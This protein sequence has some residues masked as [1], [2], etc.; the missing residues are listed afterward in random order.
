MCSLNRTNTHIKPDPLTNNRHYRYLCIEKYLLGDSSLKLG[1]SNLDQIT[2][3]GIAK[4]LEILLQK[5]AKVCQNLRGIILFCDSHSNVRI[6]K[7]LENTAIGLQKTIIAQ[8]GFQWLRLYGSSAILFRF[9]SNFDSSSTT[10]RAIELNQVD[11]RLLESDNFV[12]A[13]SFCENLRC[14]KITYC[15]N[16]D[17]QHWTE[18]ARFFK[19]LEYFS[20]SMTK[21]EIPVKFLEQIF[22]SAGDNLKYLKIDHNSNIASTILDELLPYWYLYNLQALEMQGL[23]LKN[24]IVSLKTCKKLKHLTIYQDTINVNSSE[25]LNTLI[26]ELPTTLESLIVRNLSG[27]NIAYSLVKEKES[28]RENLNSYDVKTNVCVNY[29]YE[30]IDPIYFK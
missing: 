26:K 3:I 14:L 1:V 21:E 22:I 20:I 18:I 23:N 6:T 27:I 5:L 11:L 2:T 12:E 15:K 24:A 30:N 9:I 19:K 8:N 13:L 28:K 7:Q 16:L 25:V 17:Q 29:F 4:D 10:L